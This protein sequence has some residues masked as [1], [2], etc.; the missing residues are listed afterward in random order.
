MAK[1]RSSLL[2]LVDLAGSERQRDTRTEGLRL[3][4]VGA[5]LYAETIMIVGCLTFTELFGCPNAH[6][7]GQLK[8]PFNL[9]K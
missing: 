6:L 5:K 1:I 2:N 8:C 9:K 4:V 3:K 7:F